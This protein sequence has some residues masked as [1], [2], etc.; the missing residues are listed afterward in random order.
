MKTNIEPSSNRQKKQKM[1]KKQQE[2]LHLIGAS[3]KDAPF[4]NDK[5]E[6]LCNNTK[7]LTRI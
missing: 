3:F 7:I 1:N 4:L 2:T 5:R 6:D